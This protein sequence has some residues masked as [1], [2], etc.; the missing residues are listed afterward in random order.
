MR[1]IAIDLAMGAVSV[2]EEKPA[3]VGS[4]DAML[5]VLTEY[6]RLVVGDACFELEPITMQ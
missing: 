2:E 3:T 4:S 5:L 6:P 1:Q